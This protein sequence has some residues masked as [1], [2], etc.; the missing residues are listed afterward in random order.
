MKSNIKKML[1]EYF[2]YSDSFDSFDGFD[3][4]ESNLK[5]EKEKLKRLPDVLTLYRI[6]SA[7]SPEVIDLKRPGSHYSMDKNNLIKTHSF[8][9]NNKYYLITVEAPK[10]LIYFTATAEN[11][12]NFPNE[13]EIT[14]KNKGAGVNIIS[15]NEI[16]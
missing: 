1:R 16:G 9:K 2:D 7:E 6:I 12:V 10:S 13:K 15:V 11:N 5:K 3:S 4:F 14:L 8:L